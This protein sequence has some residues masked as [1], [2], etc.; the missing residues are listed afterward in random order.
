MFKKCIRTTPFM[1]GAANDC[2]HNI[3]GYEYEGDCSFVSTLR[4]LLGKR[5]N[6]DDEVYL[7][8]SRSSYSARDLG[9]LDI[10]EAINLITPRIMKT[11]NGI[12]TVHSFEDSEENRVAWLTL[13]KNHFTEVFKNYDLLEKF[14]EF[15]SKSFKTF[16]FIN[17]KTKNVMIFVDDLDIRKMH[18]LQCSIVAFLP[19]YFQ[20]N[21]EN[22]G[23]TQEEMELIKSLRMRSA[24]EYE[25]ILFK[26]SEN[27]NLREYRIKQ[28][29]KGFE[30]NIKEQQIEW[31]SRQISNVDRDINSRNETINNLIQNKRELGLK[32][33]G[34]QCELDN[35]DG[36]SEIM[37]YFLRNK[38][39]ILESVNQDKITFIVR[40][41]CEYFD[42]DTVQSVIDNKR[43][44]VYSNNR[45]IDKEDC[46]RLIK[47]IFIDQK[48]HVNFCAAYTF[49]IGD[50]VRAMSHYDYGMQCENYMPNPHIDE[51]ACLGNYVT[52]INECLANYNFIGAIAQCVASCKSLNFYDTAVMNE[53]VKTLYSSRN[54]CIELPDGTYVTSKEAIEWLKNDEEG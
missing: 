4:A 12:I 9:T 2:F 18:Y 47:A 28:L 50:S 37:D 53:F 8:F 45:D 31:V 29:L 14:T 23:I 42:E 36:E 46:G 35:G 27:Y 48:L 52:P 38:N 49:W 3:S 21:D 5:I 26:I 39:L 43:S 20:P 19:W 10:A 15:Y 6:E 24:V 22:K 13:V 11:E 25:R 34:L 40:D 44:Y 17:S 33:L 41:R 7:N 16:C 32:L 51:Y 1:E 30:S 54:K